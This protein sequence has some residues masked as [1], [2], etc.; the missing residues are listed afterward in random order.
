M[1]LAGPVAVTRR[2]D[3][4]A[5]GKLSFLLFFDVLAGIWPSEHF[6]T[7]HKWQKKPPEYPCCYSL[8]V[9]KK[10]SVLSGDSDDDGGPNTYDYN[11]SFIDDKEEGKELT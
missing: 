2:S 6:D 4:K 7:Y 5:K 1:I 9:G 10:Q 8:S 11:D 3:R